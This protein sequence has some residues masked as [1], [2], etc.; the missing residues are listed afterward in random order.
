[1]C[2]VQFQLL[3]NFGPSAFVQVFA[4][5]K[6]LFEFGQLMIS[7]VGPVGIA[8]V[9]ARVCLDRFSLLFWN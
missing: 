3:R 1:L 8:A 4:C 6:F 2:L 5:V 9:C 7:K